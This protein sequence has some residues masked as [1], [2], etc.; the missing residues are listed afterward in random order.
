MPPKRKGTGSKSKP[1]KVQLDP[2]AEK[3]LLKEIDFCIC[4]FEQLR[5]HATKEEQHKK[6]E[7]VLKTL[8][9]YFTVMQFCASI[10]QIEFLP[11]RFVLPK[12]CLSL[13]NVDSKNFCP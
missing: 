5:D 11:K 10:R 9:S 1:P 6:Y 2:E 12:K 8:G 7:K 4:H 3:E 13:E